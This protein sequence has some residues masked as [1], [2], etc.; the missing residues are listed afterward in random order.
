M[1][2]ICSVSFR[3]LSGSALALSFGQMLS[4]SCGWEF[5]IGANS[6]SCAVLFEDLPV[7][8]PTQ[9]SSLPHLL[10]TAMGTLEF[11]QHDY[12][13]ATLISISLLHLAG[14]D[15]E[16]SAELL[17]VGVAYAKMT[18]YGAA[19]FLGCSGSIVAVPP[20]Y[21]ALNCIALLATSPGSRRM[22]SWT[23]PCF[24]EIRDSS[25]VGIATTPRF[26]S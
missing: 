23:A 5:P 17:N 10:G 6:L 9:L 2:M 14:V 8:A 19:R 16:L 25:V 1:P 15:I 18:R 20:P 21:Q 7:K 11:L 24:S 13:L 26:V 4:M 12:D 22:K 3:S